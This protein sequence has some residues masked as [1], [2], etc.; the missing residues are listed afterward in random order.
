RLDRPPRRL[1]RRLAA[2]RRCAFVGSPGEQV[3]SNATERSIFEQ[4]SFWR[5]APR[6]VGRAEAG[7]THVVV[8]CGTSY[9]I[10][11]SLAAGLNLVGVPA[12]AVPGGEWSRRPDA[13]LPRGHRA[14]V[15]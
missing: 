2:G 13:F 5:T 11:M 3:M 12:I 14:Q 4:F 10:A 9:N 6:Q 15:L 8:G 1:H 7:Q